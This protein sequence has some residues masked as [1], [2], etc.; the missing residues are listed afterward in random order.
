MSPRIFIL[1]VRFICKLLIFRQICKLFVCYR[2]KAFCYYFLIT[3]HLLLTA[4][5]SQ[6]KLGLSILN[7]LAREDSSVLEW[8][9]FLIW[10][11]VIGLGSGWSFSRFLISA[12]VLLF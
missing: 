9:D 10:R 7:L 4:P 1:C 2:Y 5:I 12:L 6:G 3:L 11:L 8:G